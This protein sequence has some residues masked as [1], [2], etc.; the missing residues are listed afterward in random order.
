MLPGM[1]YPHSV[2]VHDDMQALAAELAE[3]PE[4]SV[5]AA[6]EGTGVQTR[7]SSMPG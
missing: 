3:H 7:N 6:Q 1:L 4:G 2:D 5:S